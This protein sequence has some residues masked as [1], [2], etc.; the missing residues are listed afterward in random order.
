L[1]QRRL[2]QTLGLQQGCTNPGFIEQGHQ[3]VGNIEQTGSPG[4]AAAIGIV[5]QIFQGITDVEIST[6]AWGL[7]HA[8][9]L[10]TIEEAIGIDG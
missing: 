4:C 5:Q 2:G 8:E 7:V 9:G 6:G 10:H 1:E 3:Q